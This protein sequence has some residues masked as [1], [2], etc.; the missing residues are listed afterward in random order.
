VVTPV[1]RDRTAACG[2]PPDQSVFVSVF[3]TLGIDRTVAL[4]A[5]FTGTVLLQFAAMTGDRYVLSLDVSTGI[6]SGINKRQ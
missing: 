2:L 1:A 3:F 6:N 4:Q 5:R